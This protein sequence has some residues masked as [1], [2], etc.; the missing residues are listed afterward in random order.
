MNQSHKLSSSGAV[1]V[2]GAVLILMLLGL[3]GGVA[4]EWRPAQGPL[5]TRWAREV[6]PDNALREYP[7]PMM[8]RDQ[9]RNLNGL[10]DLAIVAKDAPRPATFPMQILVPFPVESALSG[11]MKAVTENERIW[12]RRT[13]EVPPTWRGQRLLLHFGAV[14]FE[15][16]VWV[17][18]KEVGRHAGGY[19]AFS[20]DITDALAASGPNELV[21]AVWD[22]TDA[23]TQPRGKQ[24]RKPH[25]IW[26]TPTSGIWQT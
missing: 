2:R 6:S 8:V 13:F 16:T 4:G 14:D 5:M 3:G 21:V 25:G 22:P 17:N 24:I 15:A 20:F 9:W 10:W 1:S 7:R 18:G 26:Y 19:D 11:V 23:G 12:Y